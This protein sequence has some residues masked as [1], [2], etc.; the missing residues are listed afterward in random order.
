MHLIT[1][2]YDGSVI[3]MQLAPATGDTPLVS[4]TRFA[5]A[6]H[7]G[8]VKTLAASGHT[9]VSTGTDERVLVYDLKKKAEYGTLL[10]HE[11]TV[12]CSEFWGGTHLLTGSEDKTV[13]IWRTKDWVSL[14]TLRV[15]GGLLLSSSAPRNSK[16]C[17]YRCRVTR[18]RWWRL[19][20]TLLA[21][22]RWRGTLAEFSTSG[23]S[24]RLSVSSNIASTRHPC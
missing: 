1:G 9:L 16:V 20:C 19:A 18:L 8:C 5:Y 6:P 21:S 2:G 10:Q 4:R 7:T 14:H 23:T 17:V 12:T 15:G 13:V 24:R 22:S 3:G 11:G